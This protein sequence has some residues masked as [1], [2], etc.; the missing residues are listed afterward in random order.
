MPVKPS[1][2]DRVFT[3]EVVSFP[4]AVHIDE[5]KDF[6]PVI[7]KALVLGG[8]TKDQ[9]MTGINGGIQVTTGFLTWN[10]IIL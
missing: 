6:T 9:H 5:K 4:G 10:C 3:T 1:Y 8:Y 2:A 7:E